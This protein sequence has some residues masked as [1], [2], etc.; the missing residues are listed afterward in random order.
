M[1]VGREISSRS[2]ISVLATPSLASSRI[3]ARWT[4]T[5]G[6]CVA[7]D[8]RRNVARSSGVTDKAAAD[9]GMHGR[10][11]PRSL[12]IKSPQRRATSCSAVQL[13]ALGIQT[14]LG[15]PALYLS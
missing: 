12:A 1:T 6:T 7:L 13:P 15:S 11:P 2:A 3:L 9:N 14:N 8:Q 10:S 4:T 5:A